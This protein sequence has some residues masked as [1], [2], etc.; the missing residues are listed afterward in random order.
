M[1]VDFDRSDFRAILMAAGFQAEDQEITNA[2]IVMAGGFTMANTEQRAQ[3]LEE[4]KTALE[5]LRNQ[6]DKT[7]AKIGEMDGSAEMAGRA[8]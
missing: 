1:M 7:L 8:G 5:T 3:A 4:F 6:L 2:C